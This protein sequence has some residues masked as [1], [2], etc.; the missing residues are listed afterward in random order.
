[1]SILGRAKVIIEKTVGDQLSAAH[2][3]GVSTLNVTDAREFAPG[4]GQVYVNGDIYSYTTADTAANT[5]ALST[6]TTAAY[7]ID[8][9]VSLYP[10][11]PFKI[12]MVQIENEGASI[13][14]FVPHE[15]MALMAEGL[16]DPGIE[17]EIAAEPTREYSYRVASVIGRAPLFDASTTPIVTSTAGGERTVLDGNGLTLYTDDPVQQLAFTTIGLPVGVA[18]DASGNVYVADQ[19]NGVVRKFF[20]D[21]SQITTGGFPITVTGGVTCVT[22]D[23]SG[24][25][26]TGNSTAVRKYNTSG[27]QTLTFAT[28][29]SAGIAVDTSG[30]IYTVDNAANLVR[31]Y[32]S[33]GTAGITISTTGLPLG[34]TVDASGNIYTNDNTNGLIRKFNAAGTQT[35]SFSMVGGQGNGIVV[36]AAGFIYVAS[37]GV[38]VKYDAAGV[39]IPGFP[40]GIFSPGS[41]EIALDAAGNIYSAD[42]QNFLIRK[43]NNPGTVIASGQLISALGRLLALN[44]TIAGNL[45]VD[46]LSSAN[47]L[48]IT[49]AVTMLQKTQGKTGVS[50]PSGTGTTSVVVTYG[51]AF[52]TTPCVHFTPHDVKLSAP[53]LTA[54]STSGFT[55][56]WARSATGTYT[57]DWTA[58]VPT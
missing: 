40:F 48:Q 11:V 21:G 50:V 10:L 58:S 24:N 46:S 3:S 4:P 18:V 9:R 56:S 16:Y 8:E 30:N 45:E 55:V 42:K 34:V 47:G 6:P 29:S 57:F 53:T 38:F 7:V 52:L 15:W 49:S 43:Y 35:L 44:A 28:T 41:I 54:S 51:V 33:A 36:D 26:Y 1:M 12:A 23:S 17:V 31:K 13:P 39:K 32:N 20:I 27:T 37:Y 25:I 5:I 2:L 19:S 14:V 22:L